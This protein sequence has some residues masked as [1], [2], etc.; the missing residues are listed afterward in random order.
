M[1]YDWAKG[2]SETLRKY[3]LVFVLKMR[4]L[5]ESSELMDAIFDQL[6]DE[7]TIDRSDLNNFIHTN[8][9]KVLILLDGFDEFK[10]KTLDESS[11][12]SI[13]KI[14]NQKKGREMSVFVT[15]RPSHYDKLVC[16][17]LVQQPF[18]HVSVL[19]FSAED[20]KQYVNRFFTNEDDKAKS[21]I[22]RIQSSD[23]LRDLAKSPMLLLLMCLLCGDNS[24]LP[25]TMSRLYSEALTYIFKRKAKDMLPDEISNIVN[26]IGKV[27]LHGLISSDQLLSFKETDFENSQLPDITRLHVNALTYIFK[28]KGKRYVTR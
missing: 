12:G 11:F 19:G 4:E 1:A 26:A 24:Q 21:L 8:P 18:T 22:Q 10:S 27:A 5:E 14:L 2:S 3:K 9:D 28:K 15:T 20:I 6:L 23:V 17:S 7:D 13:L 16:T 25:D